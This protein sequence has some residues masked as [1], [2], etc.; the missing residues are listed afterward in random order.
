MDVH[1]QLLARQLFAAG[2]DWERRQRVREW[3]SMA[4]GMEA[5]GPGI[6]QRREYRLARAYSCVDEDFLLGEA[7]QLIA[8]PAQWEAIHPAQRT[9]AFQ[10]RLYM[11][12]PE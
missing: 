10:S 7:A 3:K 1:S 5:D 2:D 6:A 12:A 9:R 4:A 8:D 11:A